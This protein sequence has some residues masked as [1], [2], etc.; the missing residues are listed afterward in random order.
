MIVLATVGCGG[1]HR[2]DSAKPGLK[3]RAASMAQEIERLYRTRPGNVRGVPFEAALSRNGRALAVGYTGGQIAVW[4]VNHPKA[5]ELGLRNAA[6]S[7]LAVSD[8]GRLLATAY[9]ADRISVWNIPQQKPLADFPVDFPTVIKFSADGTRL[10]AAGASTIVY[11][12]TTK[13]R[14]S[15][16][17][18]SYAVP[19]GP[20]TAAG[21]GADGQSVVGVLGSY[22]FVW[23]PG[24]AAP[25]FVKTSEL[26]GRAVSPDGTKIAASTG[27]AVSIWD[28]RTGQETAAFHSAN[29]I[30]TAAFLGDSRRLAV[31]GTTKLAASGFGTRTVQVFDVAR[32]LQVAQYRGAG[33]GVVDRILYDPYGLIVALSQG[34]HD[35]KHELDVFFMP[36]LGH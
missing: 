32:E 10:L 3:A 18:P 12:I 14:M 7:G 2:A 11:D 31:G 26:D 15:S 22:F 9:R 23:T 20:V 21:F 13:H 4:D 25:Q 34:G 5:P 24:K 1:G 30:L 6:A 17:L 27:D 36:G 33:E 35:R 28:V 29:Q 16:S 19:S 8:D